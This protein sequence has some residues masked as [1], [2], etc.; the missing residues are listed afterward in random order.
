[1]ASGWIW[2]PKDGIGSK[3]SEL[4][5]GFH[6]LLLYLVRRG[7]FSE[8]RSTGEQALRTSPLKNTY[9]YIRRQVRWILMDLHCLNTGPS[10]NREKRGTLL[11]RPR[12]P[13]RKYRRLV[14]D[15]VTFDSGFLSVWKSPLL[16]VVV[17]YSRWPTL[18]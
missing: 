16:V 5:C 8:L 15:K 13:E 6:I 3:L 11:L 2:D 10:L 17:R 7:H 18:V 4:S 12:S 1:M 14:N 9:L